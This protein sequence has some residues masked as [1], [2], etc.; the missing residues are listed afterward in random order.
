MEGGCEHSELAA[1]EEWRKVMNEA[2]DNGD[3]EIDIE[4]FKTLMYR[5]VPLN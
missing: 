4:E 1:I 2:D 5:I 3:G